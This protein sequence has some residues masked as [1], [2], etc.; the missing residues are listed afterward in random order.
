MIKMY[1]YMLRLLPNGD[2]EI[3]KCVGL[4]VYEIVLRKSYNMG[5]ELEKNLILM[6]KEWERLCD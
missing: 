3:I 2:I 5:D 6:Y 1:E 4:Q